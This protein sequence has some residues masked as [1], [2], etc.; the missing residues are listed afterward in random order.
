MAEP[1]PHVRLDLP[2]SVLRELRHAARGELHR[3]ERKNRTETRPA[4]QLSHSRKVERLKR[5][6][7]AIDAQVGDVRYGHQAG[8]SP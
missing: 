8:R 1:D 5:F 3:W 6:L 7:D 4:M 2:L